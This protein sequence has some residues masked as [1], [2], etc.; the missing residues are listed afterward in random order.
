MSKYVLRG[1]HP[2]EPSAF[3]SDK[4]VTTMWKVRTRCTNIDV[5]E[6]LEWAQ[7]HLIVG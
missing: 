1:S 6:R 4:V 2:K 7:T 5:G 3:R